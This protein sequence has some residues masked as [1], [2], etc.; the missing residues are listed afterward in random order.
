MEQVLVVEVGAL[1][2]AGHDLR[3][4]AAQLVGELGGA[5]LGLEPGRVAHRALAIAHARPAGHEP[6][7]EQAR[8][9]RREQSGGDQRTPRRVGHRR[10]LQA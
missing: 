7:P 1:Y 4:L 3:Q 2:L 5:L 9:Q 8:E 6:R 10:S